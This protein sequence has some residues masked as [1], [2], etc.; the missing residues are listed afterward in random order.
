MSARSARKMG[1][2]WFGT[3]RGVTRYVAPHIPAPRPRV[4]VLL[5]KSYEPGETLPSIERGRRVDLKIDVADHKTRSELRRFRWQVVPGR[6]TAEA[7]PDPVPLS[8]LRGREGEV[9]A[10]R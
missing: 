6:P 5:D 2:L 4:T 9:L 10:L 1:A 8:P 3:D 7:L